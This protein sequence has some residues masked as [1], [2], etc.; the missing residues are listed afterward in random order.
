MELLERAISEKG[1]VLPGNVLK[2]GSIINNQID[3]SLMCAMADEACSRFKD[4]GVTKVLTVEASGIAFAVLIAE[5][6]KVDAVFAKKSKTSNVEGEVYSARCYSYTHKKE[7]T[8]IIPK[9][10]LGS[11]DTVLIADD[12]L[13]NGE[14][15]SALLDMANRAGARVVGAAIAVEKGFQGGGDRLRAKGLEVFSLAVIDSMDGGKIVFRKDK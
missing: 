8:L 11:A 9:E 12:F 15:V 6:L 14:A 4:K 7:N 13:A 5:R 10:Y 1:T 3:I 2:V